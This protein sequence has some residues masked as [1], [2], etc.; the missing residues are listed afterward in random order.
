MQKE[1]IFKI[2]GKYLALYA[3]VF[4]VI[5]TIYSTALVVQGSFLKNWDKIR[6][7]VKERGIDE[8]ANPL[9]Y[10]IKIYKYKSSLRTLIRKLRIFITNKNIRKKKF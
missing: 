8:G 9:I 7:L 10:V 2:W 5:S 4:L 3:K 1:S 6:A